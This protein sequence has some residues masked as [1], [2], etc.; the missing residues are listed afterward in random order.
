M[1]SS[2]YAFLLGLAAALFSQSLFAAD[3]SVRVFNS[4][5]IDVP[6]NS[7]LKLTFDRERFDTSKFHDAANPGVLVVPATGKY[8]IYCSAYF[9]TGGGVRVLRIVRN[10]SQDLAIEVREAVQPYLT[11]LNAFTHFR[12]VAGDSIEFNVYQ[13]S[14]LT[15]QVGGPPNNR[16][17][18]CGMFKSG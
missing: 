17:P 9:P 2:R 7:N 18:E 4:T 12:L 10:G 1:L 5:A 6:D 11:T 16:G 3:V 14:G 13:D 15:V 8:A